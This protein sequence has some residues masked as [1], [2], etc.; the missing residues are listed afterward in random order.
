VLRVTDLGAHATDASSSD[1]GAPG[2]LDIEDLSSLLGRVDAAPEPRYLVRPII[3]A[4]DHGMLGAESKAGKTWATTD[5]AV[6]VASSTPWLGIFEVQTPG[7]VLLFA[8][9]GGARKIARRFRAVCESRCI[10]PATLP[11]RV[12]LRVPHLTSEAAMLLVEEEIAHCRAVL[13]IIDPLYLAARGARGSDLYEMGAHLE[14]AQSIC[15]RHGS[16]L[17]ITHHWNKTGD[18]RGAKRMSGAGPDAWGRVLIS[19]AVVSRHTDPATQASSVVLDIDLQGDEIAETTTRI[20]RRVWADNAADLGSALHYEI[21]RVENFD[22]P[23]DPALA[24]LP[25]SALRVL[26]M[27]NESGHWETTRTIGDAVAEAGSPLR[28]RTIQ[29]ALKHLVSAGL[30][31]SNGGLGASGGKWCARHA[32]SGD[33]EAENAL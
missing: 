26:Q 31:V 10:D 5:L 12:C 13:V 15:Q 3:A 22:P 17:L 4:G 11:V 9:E 28:L 6:S 27:L 7:P 18:G 30:A 32:H 8:G 2:L 20:V 29:S 21:T 14:A 23:S 25:P 16:A 19:A 1:V 33:S 24:D